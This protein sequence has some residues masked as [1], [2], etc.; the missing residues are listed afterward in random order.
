MKSAVCFAY[1]YRRATPQNLLPGRPELFEKLRALELDPVVSLDAEEAF[2]D[3]GVQAWMLIE[4]GESITHSSLGRL[5][6]GSD[7][8]VIVNRVGR[9]LKT[10][11]ELPPMINENKTRSLGHRKWDAYQKVLLPLGI[12]IETSLVNTPDDVDKFLETTQAETLIVKPQIGTFGKGVQRVERA[13]AAGLFA[14]NQ[15]WYGAY[16]LQPAYDI[17]STF[18]STIRPYDHASTEDFERYN[19]KGKDK[20]LRM[21]GFHANG[22]TA[23]FPA[24]RARHNDQDYW[25]FVDPD[26]IPH[27]VA[28]GA[29]MAID[30]AALASGAVALYGTADYV[31]GSSRPDEDQSWKIMEMNMRDPYLIGYDKHPGVADKLRTMFASQ[32]RQTVEAA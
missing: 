18:P 9:S 14:A 12:G 28:A 22:K 3:G 11:V 26:T 24:A 17:Q 15:K 5:A 32:I 6:L 13:K 8:P 30:K 19:A 21:Y 23:V 10:T 7:V 25:F 20:E 27:E 2:A 4:H 16:I 31:W 29:A 1:R